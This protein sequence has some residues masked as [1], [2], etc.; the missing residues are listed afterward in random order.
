VKCAF[1]SIFSA[2]LGKTHKEY[3]LNHFSK[4]AKKLSGGQKIPRNTSFES[5]FTGLFRKTLSL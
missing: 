1:F 4:S 2:N 5:K 3:I